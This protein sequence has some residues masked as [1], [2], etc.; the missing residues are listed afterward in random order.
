MTK[1]EKGVLSVLVLLIVFVIGGVV[2]GLR[3]IDDAGGLK[4]VV[5]DAGKEVKEIAR[6]IAKD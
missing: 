3:A 5:I 4:A 1:V 2:N 6:E